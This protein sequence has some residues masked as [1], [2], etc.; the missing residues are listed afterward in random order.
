MVDELF[1][2]V[3]KTCNMEFFS[4]EPSEFCSERCRQIYERNEHYTPPRCQICGALIILPRHKKYR[5]VNV[6]QNCVVKGKVK[7]LQQFCQVCHELL[8]SYLQSLGVCSLECAVALKFV[9]Y[10]LH[11][12]EPINV[13]QI[14][15]NPSMIC[16]VCKK[17]IIHHKTLKK[18]TQLANAPFSQVTEIYLMWRILKGDIKPFMKKAHKKCE[19][20]ALARFIT[21]LRN[22]LSTRPKVLPETLRN[23]ASEYAEL[24]QNFGIDMLEFMQDTENEGLREYLEVAYEKFQQLGLVPEKRDIRELKELHTNRVLGHWVAR[25]LEGGVHSATTLRSRGKMATVSR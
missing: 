24:T 19:S 21:I 9:H 1:V 16:R 13:H 7:G 11:P 20:M 8:P 2:G 15:F 3:C 12:P 18:A 23:V 4:N 6:C 10:I 14:H 22:F 25:I 17:P 5:D